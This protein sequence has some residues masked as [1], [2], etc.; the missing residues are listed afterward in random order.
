MYIE[1]KTGGLTGP[2]RIG[3]VTFSKTGRTLHYQGRAFQSLKGAGFKA[4]YYDTGS[5]AEYWISGPK[6]DGSDRLYG[7]AVPVEIDDDAR[8]EYWREIRGLPNKAGQR[9]ANR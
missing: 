6:K 2:A 9:L 3:R 8:E 5:G 1:S 4:N 7:E